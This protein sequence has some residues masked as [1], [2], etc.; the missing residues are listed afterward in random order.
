[1]PAVATGGLT[2]WF[3]PQALAVLASDKDQP[4]STAFS[5]A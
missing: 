2:R 4:A 3:H 5:D 1:M